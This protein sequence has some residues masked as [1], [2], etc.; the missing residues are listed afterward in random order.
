[1][2]YRSRRLG[3]MPPVGGEEYKDALERVTEMNLLKQAALYVWI[4]EG[5]PSTTTE[6]ISDEDKAVTAIQLAKVS[7]GE[8]ESALAT[9]RGSRT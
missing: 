6:H 9:F 2:L 1:M 8:V 4:G 3:R 5:G 7:L